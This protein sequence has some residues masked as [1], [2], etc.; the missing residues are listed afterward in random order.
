[1]AKLTIENLAIDRCKLAELFLLGNK[2]REVK[3]DAATTSSS[4][5]KQARVF[6]NSGTS[7]DYIIGAK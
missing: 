3:V 6:L 4:V 2:L 5:S 1:M 7:R